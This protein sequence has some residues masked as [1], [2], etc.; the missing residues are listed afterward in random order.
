MTEHRPLVHIAIPSKIVGDLMKGEE[1]ELVHSHEVCKIRGLFYTDA[2]LETFAKGF[3]AILNDEVWVPH[4]VL[5]DWMSAAG[6]IKIARCQGVLSSR[7]ITILQQVASGRSNKEISSRLSISTNTVKAHLYNIYKK[8]GVSNRVQ[9]AFWA[10]GQL[11]EQSVNR[12]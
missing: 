5:M 1:K 4:T 10:S 6:T 8:L 11:S 7:E 12:W 9:A 3:T 2:P